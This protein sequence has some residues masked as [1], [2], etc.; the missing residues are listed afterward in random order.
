MTIQRT[1]DENVPVREVDL[2]EA[3]DR[4]TSYVVVRSI[5]DLTDREPEDLEPL[6]DSVDPEA[7]DSF[8]AHASESSTPYQLSFRYQG[9]TVEVV[10]NRWLRIFSDEGSQSAGRA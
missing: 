8:V 3:T 6:W 7:L 2:D 10:G 9:Y 1:R 4:S 5:A